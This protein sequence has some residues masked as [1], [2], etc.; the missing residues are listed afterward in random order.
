VQRSALTIFGLH[1]YNSSVL[2]IRHQQLVGYLQWD[3]DL[4]G[5]GQD[6]AYKSCFRQTNDW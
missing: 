1:P 2:I 4:F 3:N 6:L 5:D